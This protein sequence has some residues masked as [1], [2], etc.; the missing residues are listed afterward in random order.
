VLFSTEYYSFVVVFVN[1][2]VVTV[3]PLLACVVVTRQL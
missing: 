1:I 3:M 2:V